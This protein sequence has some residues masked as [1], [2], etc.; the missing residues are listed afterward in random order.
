MLIESKFR[1]LDIFYRG[2]HK[3]DTENYNNDI[4]Q[5]VHTK[6]HIV[7]HGGVSHTQIHIQSRKFSCASSGPL[8]QPL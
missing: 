7:P 4:S 3:L 1:L 8:N 5:L 6:N 2:Q